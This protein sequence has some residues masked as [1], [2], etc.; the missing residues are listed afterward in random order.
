MQVVLLGRSRAHVDLVGPSRVGRPAGEVLRSLMAGI[1]AVDGGVQLHV[2]DRHRA[3]GVGAAPE[4]DVDR[5]DRPRHLRQL[6]DAGEGRIRH[7]VLPNP[8]VED[9][10]RCA[11]AR[12]G[13][14]RAPRPRGGGDHQAC[15]EA[16]KNGQRQP[17]APTGAK[18]GAQAHAD[19]RHATSL[20]L[21][22]VAQRRRD[23]YARPAWT[24]PARPPRPRAGH[25]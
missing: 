23:E 22:G 25:G 15:P 19:G 14:I 7:L 17:G 16:G 24:R 2:V 9:L 21:K 4:S 10:R 13:V 12:H 11:V 20:P 1:R 6:L 3:A 8:D 18:L 5:A